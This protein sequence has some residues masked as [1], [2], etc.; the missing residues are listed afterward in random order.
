MERFKFQK[1]NQKEGESVADYIV[2]LRQ[3]SV[4]FEFGQYLSDALRDR[5]VSG[6]NSESMQRKLLSQKDLMFN[7]ACEIASSLELAS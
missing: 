2:A 6:L 5:F 1:R 7:Q 3:L 4:S